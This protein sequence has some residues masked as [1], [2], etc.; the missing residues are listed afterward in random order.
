MIINQK[1]QTGLC[2]ISINEPLNVIANTQFIK[3]N[4]PNPIKGN[5]IM[6]KKKESI[7]FMLFVFFS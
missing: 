7:F 5:M 4:T 6:P 3:L 1:S 2:W